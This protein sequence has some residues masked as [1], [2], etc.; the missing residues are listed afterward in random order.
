[1]TSHRFLLFVLAMAVYLVGA[2]EFMLSAIMAPLANAFK[3]QTQQISWL[4]SAYALSYAFAAPIIGFFSDKMDKRKI[5]LAAIL[6][7]SIDSLAI[8]FAANL[9]IALVLRVFGGVA[10]A[11]LIPITFAFISD[12]IE[13]KKQAMA[14][15]YAM[16]GMTLGIIT[17]PVV[18]GGLVHYFSWQTPFIFMALGG[19]LVLLISMNTLP[20]TKSPTV[21]QGP[22]HIVKLRVISQFIIAKGI[23][24][25][26][27]VSLF[28]LAGEILRSRY[29][30]NSAVIGS[31]MGLFGAGLIIGNSAVGKVVSPRISESSQLLVMLVVLFVIILLFLSELLTLIGDCFSLFGLGV[32]LGLISPISTSLLARL[33]T[34]NKGFVLS[35]S[36]SVNNLVL[37]LAIPLFSFLIANGKIS[38][39]VISIGVLFSVAILLV[40]L[41]KTANK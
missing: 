10:S 41:T 19:F 13:E 39:L 34:D 20:C 21:K 2:T 12:V 26:I 28:L 23:W 37:L 5:L 36:E 33:N 17:G 4:V 9:Q 27:T 3:T 16:L 22:H 1:M 31:V 14:M 35:I 25:G 32:L 29:Q 18:A 7:I 15:G 24:N 40:N 11:A 30:L 6:F 38:V 8:I